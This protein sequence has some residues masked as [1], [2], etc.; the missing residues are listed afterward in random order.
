MKVTTYLP[1]FVMIFVLSAA[2]FAFAESVKVHK[3][4]AMQKSGKHRNQSHHTGVAPRGSYVGQRTGRAGQ[5][6]MET[7]KNSSRIDGTGMHRRH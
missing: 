2:H 5:I 4:V 1:V 7:R 6:G 3:P